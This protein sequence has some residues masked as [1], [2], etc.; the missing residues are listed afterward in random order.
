[1]NIVNGRIGGGL[2]DADGFPVEGEL[3]GK[4]HGKCGHNALTH[5]GFADDQS[6]VIVGRNMDPGVQGVGRFLFLLRGGFIFLCVGS[7]QMETEPQT[8]A[9]RG[10]G[11]EE[12]TSIQERSGRHDATPKLDFAR[13]R[14]SE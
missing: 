9:C 4:N 14:V 8:G 7:G 1:M 13:K 2:L 11:F 12:R 5:F 3:L 6:D 10:G